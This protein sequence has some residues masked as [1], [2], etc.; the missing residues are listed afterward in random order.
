M[1]FGGWGRCNCEAEEVRFV[2]FGGSIDVLVKASSYPQPYIASSRG[3]QSTTDMNVRYVR[4]IICV[5]YFKM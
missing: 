5:V 2:L 3:L 1:V 4:G